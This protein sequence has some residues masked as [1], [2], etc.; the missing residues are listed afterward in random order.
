[1]YND[2]TQDPKFVEV[3]CI[4]NEN[5]TPNVGRCRQVVVSSGLTIRLNLTRT[6]RSGYRGL[7]ALYCNSKPTIGN[8]YVSL[9]NIKLTSKSELQRIIR[10]FFSFFATAVQIVRLIL[11]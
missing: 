2:H 4:K 7:S 3:L 5:E 1:M 8:N 9:K 11:Q 10:Q 6:I